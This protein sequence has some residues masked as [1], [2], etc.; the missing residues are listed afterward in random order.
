MQREPLIGR[1]VAQNTV[2]WDNAAKKNLPALIPGTSLSNFSRNCL[3]GVEEDLPRKTVSL[4][5]ALVSPTLLEA[6]HSYMAS[7]RGVRNGWILSTEPEPSSNSI[8]CR[9]ERQDNVKGDFFNAQ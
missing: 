5:V 8:T 7:S 2:K 1:D 4:V 3:R 6:T 9:C